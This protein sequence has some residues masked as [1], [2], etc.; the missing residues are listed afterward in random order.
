M[1]PHCSDFIKL[2]TIHFSSGT[3][4]YYFKESFEHIERM[5]GGKPIVIITDKNLFHHYQSM[6]KPYKTIVIPV[7]ENHKTLEIARQITEGLVNYEVNKT[8]L[9][10]GLGG[11]MITD[12]AGFVAATY[13]RGLDFGFVPT[14]LLA[15]V[16]ASIGGKNGVNIGVYKN[17]MGTI[18]QP[19]FILFDTGFLQTL[20]DEEWANGFAEI[21]KYGCIFDKELVKELHRHHLD[22][23]KRN[24]EAL[25]RLIEQSVAFKNKTVQED[26]L[27]NGMRKLLNFGHT[28]G[29]AI[30]NNYRIAHG[31]AVA[32]G[33]MAACKLSEKYTGLKSEE[34]NSLQ[35]I[36]EQYHLPTTLK[37]DT[38]K[39]MHTL[40]MD[41]KRQAEGIDFILLE[42]MG[43]AVIRKTSFPEIEEILGDLMG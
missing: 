24:R 7:G 34:T 18:R 1:A 17:M 4:D 2:K 10:V 13:M 6:L 27:E 41:K 28:L 16:D 20:P 32:I 35:K 12:I 23:Y 40:R 31:K 42:T 3:T 33:M 22:D 30:E 15:M 8:G 5:A 26:E 25:H 39:V 14:S 11:G 9:I 38:D 37:M 36:L 29:H 19:K 21:I 43:K